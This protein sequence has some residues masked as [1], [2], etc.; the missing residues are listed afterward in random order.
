VAIA[1]S[2][3][4]LEIAL[5]NLF[6]L[7]VSLV[8]LIDSRVDHAIVKIAHFTLEVRNSLRHQWL[9]SW[10][11]VA[12]GTVLR[13]AFLVAHEVVFQLRA[14]L[15][16]VSTSV[17]SLRRHRC[18]VRLATFSMRANVHLRLIL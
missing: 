12:M 16:Q 8:V 2:F 11:D 10:R 14:W 6:G 5:D 15:E 1:L 4:S 17:L 3:A 7:L 9:L 18:N 13:S